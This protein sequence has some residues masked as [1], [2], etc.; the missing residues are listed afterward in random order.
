MP[1][2]TVIDDYVQR[3]VTPSAFERAQ[4]QDNG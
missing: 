1:K 3:I 4:A 2:S